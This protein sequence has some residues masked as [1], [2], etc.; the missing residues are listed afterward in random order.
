MNRN[1]MVEYAQ[2]FWQRMTIN[3]R[4][5]FMRRTPRKGNETERAYDHRLLEAVTKAHQEELLE[6]KAEW[7]ALRED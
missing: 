5:E 7:A 2:T 3:E 4:L 6:I 1:K